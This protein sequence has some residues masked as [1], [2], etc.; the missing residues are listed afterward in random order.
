MNDPFTGRALPLTSEGFSSVINGLR[1]DE[2]ALWSLLTVET[3]GFGFFS[4]RRPKILFERHIFHKRTGGKFSDAHPEVSSSSP[5]GYAGGTAEYDRLQAAMVLD[6][7]AALESTSWGL[8]QIMGFHA[9]TLGYENAEAMVDAFLDGEDAQLAAMMRFIQANPPLA[10]AFISKNWTKVAFYYN[11]E[12][13]AKNAYDTKL[14]QFCKLY[15]VNGVPSIDIRGAQARLLYLGL[16]P[17]G[18]DGVAGKGTH[19]ALAKFQQDKSLNVTGELDDATREA[20]R[21]ATDAL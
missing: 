10:N 4:D 21:K 9:N 17:H 20:L 13:Y 1:V 15:E 6:R 2:P 8:P 5:G 7:N 12:A 18:V 16:D 11:G 19:D 14:A 3:K